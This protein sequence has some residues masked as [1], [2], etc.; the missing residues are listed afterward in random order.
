MLI[1]VVAVSM[2]SFGLWSSLARS[3]TTESADVWVLATIV[4]VLVMYAFHITVPSLLDRSISLYILG[5]THEG[6]AFTET[7]YKD[8]F[9]RGFVEKN[10]AIEKRLAEQ[11]RTG[12]IV[13]GKNGRYEL[14]QRGVAIHALNTLL[15]QIFN[16]DRRYVDP[17]LREE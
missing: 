11:L 8:C 2:I 16:T 17:G 14:T 15:V 4:S 10:G 7:A 9:V 3:E 12:N 1:A 5:L 13:L 6:S